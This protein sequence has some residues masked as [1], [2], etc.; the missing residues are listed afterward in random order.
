MSE[1]LIIDGDSVADSGSRAICELAARGAGGR[2]L[3]GGLGLGYLTRAL[4]A[5]P[6]VTGTETVEILRGV[7]DAWRAAG[8]G[9]E[10]MTDRT[11]ACLVWLSREFGR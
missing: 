8:E 6:A 4:R 1:V 9:R 2:A 10:A 3:V 11:A 5:Q 7:V